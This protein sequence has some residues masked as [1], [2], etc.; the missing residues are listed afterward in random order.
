MNSFRTLVLALAMAACGG[1]SSTPAETPTSPQPA[2][3]APSASGSVLGIGE[4]KVKDGDKD[5][6]AVHANGDIQFFVQNE[7]KT[8]GKVSADGKFVTADGQT[9]QLQPDGSFTTPDGPAPFKLEGAALVAGP[10][11]I[12]IENGKIVGGKEPD[13]IV[14]TG[15]DTDGTKRTTLLL[16]GLVVFSQ[17]QQ[18]PAAGSAVS[19]PPTK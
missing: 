18:A 12:S 5:V 7:W 9:G 1:S 14:I 4:I 3:T 2:A 17:E 15:A 16:L 19:A 10:T 11:R 8:I 13:T 6:F